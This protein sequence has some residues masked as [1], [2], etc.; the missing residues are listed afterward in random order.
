MRIQSLGYG[1]LIGT[2]KSGIR[3]FQ[4]IAENGTRIISSFKPGE[5]AP[6]KTVYKYADS[7]V[8]H[9]IFRE[10]IK[11]HCTKVYKL[12][13]PVITIRS[14]EMSNN[15]GEKFFKEK[16][17]VSVRG[18]RIQAGKPKISWEKMSLVPCDGTKVRQDFTL[19]E[20]FNIKY[21]QY[22]DYCFLG[23]VPQRGI[24]DSIDYKI[25]LERSRGI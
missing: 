14:E 16:E 4:D 12:D 19:Y 9:P 17:S 2:S 21:R 15:L 3:V 5:S 22:L 25:A 10:P 7:I 24:C 1:N 13:E 6:C 23:S 11:C 20:D 8:E 18:E